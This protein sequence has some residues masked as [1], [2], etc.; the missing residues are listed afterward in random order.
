MHGLIQY[1]PLLLTGFLEHAAETYPQVQIVSWSDNLLHRYTYA[2]AASRARRLASSLQRRGFGAGD[3]IGSLAWTTHR[4]FELMYAVPGIGAVLH[5]ANP[6]LSPEHLSYTLNHSEARLLFV[7]PECL[8]QVEELAPALPKIESFVLMAARS[9]VPITRL[10]NVLFY[11]DLI[12]EG[13]ERFAW[14]SVDE[15]S[16]STLCFTSGTTGDPKGI[17]YSHRG[18]YLSTLAIA[19]ANVWAVSEMD[20]VIIVAPFFHCNGWGAPYLGPMA[21]AKLVLPGRALDAESLQRF[22]VDEGA[23]VGPAV[24]TVWHAIAEHCKLTGKRLGELN[25]IICGGAAPP[26]ALM[27]TYWREF[28]VRTVQVWG[29]TETTHAATVLW[30]DK[31]VLAGKAEPRTPQGRPVFGTEIRIVDEDGRNLPKDG[32]TVGHLQVRGH[33]CATGYLRRPDVEVLDRDGWLKTG[34]LAAIET[35]SGLRITDRLKDVIKSGG[36]WISS[37]DLENAATSHPAVDEAA[38]IGVPHPHWQ[39]RPVMFVVVRSG[40]VLTAAALQAHLARTVAKWWLPDDVVFVEDLPHYATGKVRK[41]VLRTHHA[42]AASAKKA[43]LT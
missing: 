29:M 17:L 37:I 13:D 38:V 4:H 31:E 27:R 23:T 40:H 2:D 15:R 20:T 41:D 30:T 11:E 43:S 33:S 36:E 25:R 14:P 26:L 8:A 24:P 10:G 3:F 22:I 39:E 28:G 5:T 35:G 9:E 6:R 42:A 1:Q 7:D 32:T 19:A 34:D 12:A 21:G 16:G 18:T